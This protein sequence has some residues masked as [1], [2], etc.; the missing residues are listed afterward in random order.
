MKPFDLDKA[1]AGHPIVYR[2]GDKPKEWHYFKESKDQPITTI[3]K[4]GYPLF[5]N[6]DGSYSIDKKSHAYDLFLAPKEET[7]WFVVWKTKNELVGT[8]TFHTE[9]GA[10]N[11]IENLTPTTTVISTF[12]KTFEV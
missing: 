12:S 7:L 11:H 4:A 3:N 8:S 6:N 10:N 2:N 9:A 1:L 5:H